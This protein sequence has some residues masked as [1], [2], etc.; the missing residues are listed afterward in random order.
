VTVD[1]DSLS[2]VPDGLF[3]RRDTGGKFDGVLNDL[4]G[5]SI[6]KTF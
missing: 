1:R 5:P 3:D 6:T 2:V 4:L